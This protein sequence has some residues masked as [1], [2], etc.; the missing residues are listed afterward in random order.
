MP[1]QSRPIGSQKSEEP[2]REQNPRRTLFDDWNQ[3]IFWSPSI[4]TDERGT[5]VDTKK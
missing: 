5:S 2:H 3:V 4:V 1:V